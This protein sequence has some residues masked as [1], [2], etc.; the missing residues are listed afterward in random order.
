MIYGFVGDGNLYESDEDFLGKWSLIKWVL[1]DSYELSDFDFDVENFLGRI[2]CFFVGLVG[3]FF[4][5]LFR[6]LSL[7]DR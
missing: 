7:K 5:G 3:G 1:F 6:E 4:D 2:N